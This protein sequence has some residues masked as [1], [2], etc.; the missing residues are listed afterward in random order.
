MSKQ[1]NGKLSKKEIGL[2]HIN[3]LFSA[4]GTFLTGLFCILQYLLGNH[5]SFAII[6]TIFAL[7]ILVI[8]YYLSFGKGGNSRKSLWKFIDTIAK[9]TGALNPIMLAVSI[10]LAVSTG[11]T[12][13]ILFIGCFAL[14]I[15]Q[16]CVVYFV[17]KRNKP[18]LRN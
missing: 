6:A 16:L 18:R 8:S 14:E 17:F 13:F 2:N 4:F 7:I 1:S 10:L 3:T 9:G 5:D 12:A 15:A 11:E